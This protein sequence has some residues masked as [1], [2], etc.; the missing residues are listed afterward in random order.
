V[1]DATPRHVAFTEALLSDPAFFG[2]QTLSA[3]EVFRGPQ[4]EYAKLLVKAC[5]FGYLCVVRR[6]AVSGA[7]LDRGYRGTPWR[8]EWKTQWKP[9]MAAYIKKQLAII[10]L[11]LEMGANPSN[12]ERGSCYSH[13]LE[14]KRN[15]AR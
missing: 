15:C 12:M 6:I 4:T 14:P 8:A 5:A 2:M 1:D 11:L 7:D 10:D 9:I 3:K 13:F